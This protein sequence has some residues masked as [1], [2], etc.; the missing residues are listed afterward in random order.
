MVTYYYNWSDQVTTREGIEY[1]QPDI[2]IPET[3]QD[4]HDRIST[5]TSIRGVGSKEIGIALSKR[6]AETYWLA[7]LHNPCEVS[8]LQCVAGILKSRNPIYQRQRH[9]YSMKNRLQ[10][11]SRNNKHYIWYLSGS[12]MAELIRRY[13]RK[14]EAETIDR[15]DKETDGE[16]WASRGRAEVLIHCRKTWNKRYHRSSKFLGYLES[17]RMMRPRETRNQIQVLVGR[18]PRQS[19]INHPSRARLGKQ[20]L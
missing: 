13:S 1:M 12:L 4:N 20:S 5:R 10:T 16:Q 11:V 8:I 6:S 7:I 17:T 2:P 3:V 14:C 19:Y 9:C 18:F 15:P